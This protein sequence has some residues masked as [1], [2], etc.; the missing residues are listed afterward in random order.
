MLESTNEPRPFPSL[1]ASRVTS[2]CAKALLA[3]IPLLF[4]VAWPA[5]AQHEFEATPFIGAR[6]GGTM[7]FPPTST[8]YQSGVDSYHVKGSSTYGAI[9]GYTFW[10]NFQAEFIYSHQPTDLSQH[11]IGTNINQHL[12]TANVDLYQ[13]GALYAFRAGD[14]KLRPFVLG[15]AGFTRFNSAGNLP[16]RNR[17]SFNLGLGA[18]Y[19]FGRHFGVRLEG[20]WVPTLTNTSAETV[21]LFGSPQN[22]AI[23]NRLEQAEANLGFIFRFR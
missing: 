7:N 16:F 14:A 9:L 2:I 5:R 1:F 19:F 15:G 3:A 20:R 17:P 13:W 8:A 12:T 18:K 10:Q 11:L 23:T 21:F 4:L 22:F 6:F